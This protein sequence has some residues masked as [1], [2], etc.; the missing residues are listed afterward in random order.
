MIISYRIVFL[1]FLLS[2][3][4]NI[5]G[6]DSTV[7]NDTTKTKMFDWYASP[8]VF[9]SPETNLTFGIGGITYFRTSRRKFT[10]P[11]KVTALA[12]YSINNQYLLSITPVVYLDENRTEVSAEMYLEH[13]IDEF[14]GIG[15]NS[16]DIQNPDYLNRNYSINAKYKRNFL[17]NIKFTLI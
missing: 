16:P 10:R 4:I 9:Y 2:I 13:A 17:M 1:A 11:S 15:N 5:H 7:T 3:S 12:H 6:Q 14:Y 8:F